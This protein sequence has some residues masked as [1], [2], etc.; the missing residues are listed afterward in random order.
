MKIQLIRNA[1]LIIHAANQHILVDPM[2]GDKG[3]LPPYA[4]FRHAPRRNPTVPLPPNTN[5]ALQHITAALITHCRRGH[6]DHLD[7]PGRQWLSRHKIITYCNH[8]DTAHLQQRGIKTVSLRPNQP[9]KFF[10]GTINPIETEHGYGL[11]GKLMGPGVGYLIN[12]PGEPSLYLSGDTVLTPTV[13]RVLTGQ[14][15]DIAVVAAGS[16]GLDVGKPILMPPDELLEFI[17]LAPGVVVATHLEALNHCPTT[18][19]QLQ[20]I[21]EQAGLAGKLRIPTDGEQISLPGI[22]ELL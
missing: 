8:L 7:K 6:F 19:S 2:L 11:L 16:A 15:P 10:G 22:E 20:Q 17:D 1:T 9:H 12:L 13:R 21:A 14:Q 5:E 4:F 18:R 3:S